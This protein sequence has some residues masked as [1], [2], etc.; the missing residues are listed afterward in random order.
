MSMDQASPV[1]QTFQYKLLAA[2]RQKHLH[3]MVDLAGEI[4]NRSIALHRVYFRVYRRHLG[5]NRPQAHLSK[6]KHR[7]FPRWNELNSQAIQQVA[8]RIYLGYQKFFAS[9]KSGRPARRPTFKK[10]SRFRSFTLKQTGW[11]LGEGGRIS[12]QG[13]LFRFY[14]SQ[15]IVGTIK[16]VT[17]KRHPLGDIWISFSCDRVPQPEPKAATGKSAGFDFGPRSFPTASDVTQ[18]ENPQFLKS[19]LGDLRKAH[20]AFSKRRKGGEGRRRAARALA[21]RYRRVRDLR[22]DWHWKESNR[23]VAD[24]DELVF[25]TLDM[26]EMR[27]RWGRKVLGYAFGSFLRRVSWLAAKHG[28]VFRRIDRFEPSTKR[29]S[30]CR[31]LQPLTLDVRRWKCTACGSAHGRDRNAAV[32]I[33][34]AGRGLR[35]ENT[36][37]PASQAVFVTSAES[38]A[39]SP[40]V[41]QKTGALPLHCALPSFG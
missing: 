29:C 6:L 3:R 22:C 33:L 8:D 32:N 19:A 38:G 9:A 35:R 34:E 13:R 25:E 36:L 7:R 18:V 26:N 2:K 15:P 17:L 37:S 10:P 28:R 40:G 14:K 4:W 31:H 20:R 21:R 24:H 30:H 11:K 23:L 12:L 27:A 16:T 41:R 39:V 5:K 1:R